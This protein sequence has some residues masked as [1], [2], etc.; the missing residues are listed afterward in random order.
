MNPIR[1][2]KG[3]YEAKRKEKQATTSG[4]S[5]VYMIQSQTISKRK[6]KDYEIQRLMKIT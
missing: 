1:T 5:N 6:T 4:K 2:S 3:K